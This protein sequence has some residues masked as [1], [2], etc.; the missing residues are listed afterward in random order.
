MAQIKISDLPLYT[1]NTSGSYLV[2]NN[3]GETTTYKVLK[4]NIV[5]DSIFAQTGSVWNTTRNVGITGSLRVDGG[6]LGIGVSSGSSPDIVQ[7]SHTGV[8]RNGGNVS[9]PLFLTTI[10][11][12]APVWIESNLLDANNSGSI[13]LGNNTS[14]TG[15]L[16]VSNGGNIT[17]SLTVS[18]SIT[19][20]GSLNIRSTPSSNN[21]L[22]YE[23]TFFRI[24]NTTSDRYLQSSGT[25]LLLSNLS[26]SVQSILQNNF[27][28]FVSASNSSTISYIDGNKLSISS[29]GGVEITGS[30]QGN[31]TPLTISSNTASLNLNSGN[32]FTLQLVSGSATHIL[33]SNIKPGQSANILISTTGSATVTFPSSVK[34]PSNMT[35]TASTGTSKDILSLLTYDTSSVY[36][37]SAK[38]LS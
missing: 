27:L 13:L 12:D 29:L 25:S 1:G 19:Q 38:T 3:S 37:I 23:N 30:V 35:Y 15:S 28:Q 33:P 14:I 20:T 9:Q 7:Y 10:G 22:R 34:Q 5:N 6:G 31:I 4:E 17:G 8:L 16:I 24:Q 26:G 2:M 32:F 21:F 18:G 36:L 11:T